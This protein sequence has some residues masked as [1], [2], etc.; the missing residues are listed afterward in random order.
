[1]ANNKDIFESKKEFSAKGNFSRL[2]NNI[3]TK[4]RLV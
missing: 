2:N 3:N 1:L 4:L